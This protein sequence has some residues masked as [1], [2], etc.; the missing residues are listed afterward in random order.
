MHV[1]VILLLVIAVLLVIFTLQNSSEIA[2]NLFFWKIDGVPLALVIISCLVLG[3][4]IATF[5]LYPR[6]WKTKR[7]LKRLKKTNTKLQEQHDSSQKTIE[8]EKNPEGIKLEDENT[9]P[10]FFND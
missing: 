1:I 10:T 4:L 5:Y 7:E 6:Y 8:T 9:N 2:L 3:Y